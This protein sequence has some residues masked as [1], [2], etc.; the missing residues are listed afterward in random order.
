MSAWPELNL[1]IYYINT[2]L[3]TT[4]GVAIWFKDYEPRCYGRLNINLH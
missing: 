3:M 2:R 1:Y 4:C